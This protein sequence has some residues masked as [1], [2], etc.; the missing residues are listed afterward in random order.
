MAVAGLSVRPTAGVQVV[1]LSHAM[2]SQAAAQ[3]L[4]QAA[5][6]DVLDVLDDEVYGHWGEQEVSARSHFSLLFSTMSEIQSHPNNSERATTHSLG[7]N[8]K[9]EATCV[10]VAS[11]VAAVSQGRCAHCDI[12]NRS[13]LVNQFKK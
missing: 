11:A 1:L 8:R 2:S 12:T 9:V 10:G 7:L 4:G 6:Q 5:I 13:F 3:S